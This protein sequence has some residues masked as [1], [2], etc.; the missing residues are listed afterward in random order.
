M[1]EIWKD[2]EG[3]EGLY[4]VSNFGRVKS[5]G[6]FKKNNQI[7]EK[8]LK[9][10]INSSGY[11][12]VSLYNKFQKTYSVHR[13]VAKAFIP[14][15]DNLPQ[16]NH[17]DENKLNNHVNNLEWCNSK[18]N[19]NYGTHNKR[20]G[21]HFKGGKNPAAKKIICLTTNEVFD[22]IRKASKKYHIDESS[23]SKVCKGKMKHIKGYVFMYYEDWLKQQY[24]YSIGV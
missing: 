24:K 14:N 9:P 4:Q 3:Y 1:E 12:Q 10:R 8:I 11:K 2:I 16:V 19:N 17:K 7:K 23:I 18:Y 6:R 15:P 20:V 13:L 21:R 22:Y 5:L